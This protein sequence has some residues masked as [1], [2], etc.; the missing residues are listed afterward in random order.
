MDSIIILLSSSTSAVRMKNAL[1]G[2]GYAAKVISTPSKLSSGGC[3]YSVKAEVG[4]AAEAERII[5]ST[6]MKS[7]GI[8]LEN[9]ADGQSRYRKL[10][11]L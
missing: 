1:I 5:N 9:T 7:R 10:P 2:K 8:Y 3:G 6:E 4:A 11:L